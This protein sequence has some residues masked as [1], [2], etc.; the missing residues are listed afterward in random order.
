VGKLGEFRANA[1]SACVRPPVC[2]H[3]RLR[4]LDRQKCELTMK[5]ILFCCLSIVSIALVPGLK[6]FRSPDRPQLVNYDKREKGAAVRPRLDP[7][8]ALAADKL[9]ERVSGVRVSVDPILGSPRYVVSTHELLSGPNGVGK[10][11]S[12]QFR[13]AIPGEDRHGSIKAF[14]NEHAAMFGHGAEILDSAVITREYITAHNGLR[15]TVW[16]QQV[17]GIPVFQ[18]I[19]IGHETKDGELASIASQFVPNPQAAAERG[20]PNHA[21]KIQAPAIS[22][23]K[24]IVEAAKNVGAALTEQQLASLDPQPVSARKQQR[25]QGAPVL[26]GETD[27][28]LTWL[29]MSGTELRLC[30]QIILT[31]RERGEMFRIII[32]AETGE[33]LV[34]HGLTEYISDASYRVFTS[35]SPSPMSPGLATPGNAQ[36]ALVPRVLVVTNAMNTNASPNG[37]INDGDNETKGNNVDAHLD[38]NKDDQPDLPRPQGNPNRVFDFAE[39]LTQQPTTYG[40]AAVVQLFYWNNFMHDKLYELGFTEA[41]GNFQ[42]TNFSRGGLGNDAV[43]A[44]AQDGSGTDNANMSTPPD[45]LPGRMQMYVFSGPNPNRDGDLDADVLLHEYTHGLS[46]RR[47]GGGAGLSSLQSRG[48]GE[49]WSDFYALSLLSESA[50]DPNATYAAGGYAAYQFGGLLQNYYYGIRH[51]PYC[52]DTNKN[53]FTFKDI[54]PGQAIPHQGIPI[55]PVYGFSPSEA[56]EVHHQ[57]EVW[58]VTLWEARAAM[59]TKYGWAVGNPLMLRLVT[60]GM[61][62]SPVNPNFLEARDAIIQADLI[63]NGGANF[64]ELWAA[65]AKRGMGGSA[66]SPASTTT[67]GVEEAFDLPGLALKQALAIDAFTGN[68][69]GSIDPNEC[70]ELKVVLVNNVRSPATTISATLATTTGGVVLSQAQ[71][72]YP[73]IQPGAT[74]TNNVPFRFTTSPGFVCGTVI[75]FTLT[76]ISDQEVRTIKLRLNTGQ[77]GT[78]ITFQNDSQI[79]IPDASPLG[80]DSPVTVSGFN[81]AIGKVTVSLYVTHTFDFDLTLVLYAP[82]GS[83]VILS[84]NNG[85]FGRNFGSA[86]SPESSRTTFDDKASTPIGL[87]RPPYVGSFKPDQPLGAFNG[88]SGTAV[89][90]TWRLHVIDQFAGDTGAIQCWSLNVS[91][92]VCAD[93]GGDCSTD[94]A[95]SGSF[96]PQI[97]LVNSNLT[98]TYAVTNRG[99]NS[100]R[101]VSFIDTL[102]PGVT[103]VSSATTKGS[104]AL[105]G[106][107]VNCSLG[108]LSVG[109]S[110]TITVVVLPTVPGTITNTAVVSSTVSDSLQTNNSS[111]LVTEILPPSPIV[112]PA[113]T[114]LIA[115]S[116]SPANGGIDPGET[117]TIDFAM[118]N[119]GSLPTANLIA[120]LLNINGVSAAS[121]SQAYGALLAGGPSRTNR[122]TFTAN[123]VAGATLN[124][125]FQLQESGTNLGT[126]VFPFILANV[127]NFTNPAVILIPDSGAAS[128][129]PSSIPV[130]GVTGLVNKVTVTLAGVNH[131][132][133]DDLDVLLVGPNGRSVLLMSDAGGG[134]GLN[135]VNLVF[136]DNAPASLPDESPITFGTYRPTDFDGGDGDAFPAPAPGGSY[137]NTLSIFNSSNPNGIWSLYVFDDAPGDSG[138]FSGGWRLNISTFDPVNATSDLAVLGTVSPNPAIYGSNLTY[139]ITVTNQGPHTATAIVLSNQIPTGTTFLSANSSQGACSN[140]NGTVVC[141][142]GTLTNQGRATVIISLAGNRTGSLTDIAR[143]SGNVDDYNLA[144]NVANI[145]STVSAAADLALTTSAAPNP[146]TISNNVAFILSITNNGPDNASAVIVTNVLPAGANFISATTSQGSCANNNGIVV[147]ALGSLAK[148]SKA[149]VT[150]TVKPL[151]V[152]AITNAAS[153]T[154]SQPV[155]SITSNNSGVLTVPVNNPA[156]IIVPAG[157]QLLSESFT[158]ATGGIDPGE[159]VTLNLGFRNEGI[160]NTTDLIATMRNSGG[161]NGSSPAQHY[162]VLSANGASVSRPFSFTASGAAG[163]VI[164]ATLD[165]VDVSGGQSNN[166]GSAAF[167]FVIGTTGRFSNTVSNGIPDNSAALI[168]PS[169]ISISGLSGV[170]SKVSVT[171]SNLT[172][173]YAD[174]LD[175]LLVSPS[176][177][178]VLLMSDAGGSSSINN[179]TLTFDDDASA[180]LPNDGAIGSGVYKPSDYNGGSSDVFPPPAPG[181]P[182]SKTLSA[183][184]GSSP[185][186]TWSLFIVD[187]AVGDAGYLAGGW[188][189]NVKTTGQIPHLARLES[190]RILNGQFQF[191]IV[192]AIGDNLVI[193]GS[194]DLQN[195]STVGNVSVGG[196]GSASFQQTAGAVANKFYRAVQP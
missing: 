185:N 64:N 67:Q 19:F 12:P 129:Y 71:S 122:Y 7:E 74:G 90:G 194:D 24:A 157:S 119:V 195:W 57:G 187:D 22:P 23:Q 130:T 183:L 147:C 193:Q 31:S 63:N 139:N 80:V 168:Y 115:E 87:G 42:N 93:G 94:L 165:L 111:V 47:V 51:Y 78:P 99:P 44:D 181:S 104:C 108:S 20:T 40:D 102:P 145:I 160:A 176:G 5:R 190:A 32:D 110:A 178:R 107:L 138:R 142:I 98:Y 133:P 156:W 11:I 126:V 172:H 163:G 106:G 149:T 184:N 30:W 83:H 153:V 82:D 43:Q 92:T 174:D 61:G 180:S 48:M 137:G 158:P 182:Y 8:K 84:Q 3:R 118:Q 36:P 16:E 68:G 150:I 143:V 164:T 39:D 69:N 152:G 125:T 58:C 1:G 159:T 60:D 192:G 38:R 155:D 146:G 59:I 123:G 27:A 148:N 151:S 186:G 88:K 105:G 54:D 173:S 166:L 177:G 131:T 188:S 13:N 6:A 81:S 26:N 18:A 28:Q 97:G 46:N 76:V 95:L 171:L 50:D 65:F 45:G 4:F 73:D 103:P 34:R 196:T 124:V 191:T 53:P 66:T 167:A 162:G 55:S 17:E 175:I 121:S 70:I 109:S 170:V 37:W 132:S 9:S 127:V 114:R 52:T 75:D 101:N 79:N 113:G 169:Q 91:P 35:D 15:T 25:F 49:G 116:L 189:L 14:L 85:F 2:L 77:I 100:A 117:V 144:N 10:A 140:A 179:S 21:A 141:G 120:N 96:K 56:N 29:P 86:C 136:D 134:F 112:V 41:A 72:S 89:N 62:L 135:N 33:V 128:P 161:V 154:S